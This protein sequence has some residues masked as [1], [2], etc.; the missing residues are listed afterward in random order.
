MR[1]VATSNDK[2]RSVACL[3]TR[4]F[5]AVRF[6]YGKYACVCVCVYYMFEYAS[7]RMLLCHSE[8]IAVGIKS[9]QRLSSCGSSVR[10]F[11]PSVFRRFFAVLV[12]RARRSIGWHNELWMA[13]QIDGHFALL[14]YFRAISLSAAFCDI[15]TLVNN[16][17]FVSD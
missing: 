7:H 13:P 5:V 11:R 15:C 10:R 14:G 6:A 12:L 9:E 8:C 3:T 4:S 16:N 1:V 17:I 2:A